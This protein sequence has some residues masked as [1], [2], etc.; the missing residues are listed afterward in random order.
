MLKEGQYWKD[1]PPDMQV[2]AMGSKLSL[3]GGKTGFFRRLNF[4][5]PSPTLV[6]NPAMPATDLCHPIENRPLSVEEYGRIQE[7]PDDWEICGPILEQYKQIGNAVP[8]KLGEAIARTILA[9]MRSERLP[10]FDGFPYSRYRDTNDVTWQV[11]M[12]KSL[13]K[14]RTAKEQ[15]NN[16]QLSL[17]DG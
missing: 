2:E 8:I 15:E 5:R 17:F 16:K 3:G 11:A 14:A 10:I 4:S 12:D 13:E 1:L 7:F 9:D 6:T